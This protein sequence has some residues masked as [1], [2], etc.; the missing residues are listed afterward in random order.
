MLSSTSRKLTNL[1]RAALEGAILWSALVLIG[2]ARAWG[3]FDKTNPL[4]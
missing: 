1:T 4:T 2:I 3:D